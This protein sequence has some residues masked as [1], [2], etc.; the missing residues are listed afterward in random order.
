MPGDAG[1][2]CARCAGLGHARAL[3]SLHLGE[4]RGLILLALAAYACW[5]F[6]R[7]AL[8]NAPRDLTPDRKR[9]VRGRGSKHR[10]FVMAG[11]VPAIHE[12]LARSEDVDAR[13]KRGHDD[14][15]T[16]A[17][18]GFASLNPGDQAV[19]DMWDFRPRRAAPRAYNQK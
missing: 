12:S 3:R 11:L 10:P 14:T 17:L 4:L 6:Y 15:F 19:V 16:S 9:Q 13:D 2:F 8:N 7:T 18:P 5:K 1:A